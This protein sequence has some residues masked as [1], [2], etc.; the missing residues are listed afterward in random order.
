M[1]L[2]GE[3]FVPKIP[4]MKVV[5]VARALAPDLPHE[6]IGIRPGEKLH[7]LMITADDAR[8][9]LALEDRYIIEPTLSFWSNAHLIGNGAAAVP[10]GFEYASHINE[11]WLDT[12][13][14]LD[15]MR[16]SGHG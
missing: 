7:E 14:L 13:T 12:E 5:D 4:S 8:S 11:D 15:L 1:V 3:L 2:G 10:E 16:E 9:T 6:M